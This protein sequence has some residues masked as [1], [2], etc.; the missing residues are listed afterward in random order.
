MAAVTKNYSGAELEGVIKSAT[1]YAIARKIDFNNLTAVHE[2]F[3]DVVVYKD[4][5]DEALKEVSWTHVVVVI[6]R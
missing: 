4:D 2:N 6:S 3:D 5:I 1:S